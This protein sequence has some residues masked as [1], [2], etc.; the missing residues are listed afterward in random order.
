M[1]KRIV[2]VFI[3]LFFLVAEARSLNL[4]E[5]VDLALANNPAIISSRRK[6]EAAEAAVGQTVS[7]FFPTLKIEGSYGNTYTQPSSMQI[8]IQ[9][10]MGA[11]T[12]TYTV[13]T[14]DVAK[15]G[16]WSASFSQPLLVP[17]LFPRHRLAWK[18]LEIARLEL[19][20]AIFDVSYDVTAAYYNLLY[21]LKLFEL[22]EESLEMAKT[23]LRQVETMVKS[24]VAT[25]ADLLRAEVQVANSEANL[26]KTRTSLEMARSVFNK[27][28]GFKLDGPVSISEEAEVELGE[29]PEYQKLLNEA[30][31]HNPD[32]RKF[33][34]S[35]E[36]AEER[37]SLE[38]TSL[39]PNFL[40]TGKKGFQELEYPSYKSEAGSWSLMGVLSWTP[41]DSFA[42]QNRIREAAAN[43]EAQKA[44][45]EE[46]KNS[47][48]LAVREA[49]LDL[50]NAQET[51]AATRKTMELAE[52]NHK[53]SD[54]R[55]LLGLGTNLEVIDAQVALTKARADFLKAKF[56]LCI[57]Q[58]KINKLVG[59]KIF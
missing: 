36:I 48:A 10:T 1:K 44:S 23:H 30:L 40:L 16:A 17:A 43:L 57:A 15:T 42:T 59:K 3:L 28:L 5:S 13:G 2:F 26:V 46:V 37:L 8:T 47:I 58:A 53:I 12:T 39:L 22:S 49:Y 27:L 50:R 35:R 34:L 55:Y 21:A 14:D 9:A 45:E 29:L 18:N 32:W 56:D 11:S 20:R 51:I 54:R 19:N 24:G 33:V 38:R 52:E 7:A 6:V 41:F 25:K 31:A 4:R